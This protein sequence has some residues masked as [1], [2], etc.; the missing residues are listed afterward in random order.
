MHSHRTSAIAIVAAL[1]ILSSVACS[2]SGNVGIDTTSSATPPP[3]SAEGQSSTTQA[4]QAPGQATQAPGQATQAP[5]QPAQAAAQVTQPPA[6]GGIATLTLDKTTFKPGEEIRAR[7]TA[8]GTFAQDAWVGLIP[9]GTPHGSVAVND[10]NDLSFQYLGGE[11]SGTLTLAAPYEP[12]SYDLRMNDTTG[13]GQEAASVTLTVVS[14][15]GE[16]TPALS[17]AKTTFAPGEEFQVQ[18]N[19]ADTLPQDAWVGI[20]PSDTPHGS[21]EVNDQYDLD[22]EYL[23]GQTSGVFTFAAPH[24]PGSYDLRLNSTVGSEG[25]EVAS[26]TFTVVSAMGNVTPTLSLDKT[27]F[28]PGEEI[29]V[30]FVTPDTFSD[31]AWVGLIPSSVPHGDENVNDENDMAYEYLNGMTSGVLTFTAPAEAGSYDFRLNNTDD[32]GQEVASVTFEVK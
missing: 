26:V 1:F 19:T 23:G 24:E 14:A 18:F 27:T 4:T 29:Q 22:Y 28:S 5:A 15:T 2:L 11:I 31:Q 25:Q 20:I 13:D 16:V 10:E 3:A 8:P 32:D 7:F 9:S 21:A 30:H 12:G 17:L 6:Q